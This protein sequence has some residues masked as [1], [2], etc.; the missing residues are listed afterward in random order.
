MYDEAA[1]HAAAAVFA[2]IGVAAVAVGAAVLGRGGLIP[3]RRRPPE[4]RGGGGEPP[5]RR[6]RANDAEANTTL[7]DRVLYNLRG[8][9]A[10]GDLAFWQKPASDVALT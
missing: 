8:G 1:L 10:G 4:D 5:A 6:P 7:A 3:G 9:S 2:L